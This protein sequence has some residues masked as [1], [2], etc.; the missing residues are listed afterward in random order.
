MAEIRVLS[1]DGGGIRGIIPATVLRYIE[2]QTGRPICDHFHL[3][4]GTSTGGILA[5]GLSQLADGKP[6]ASAGDLL[7]L[8]VD[9]GG[10]IF[11]RSALKKIR[12]VGGLTD[13]KYSARSLTRAL[14]GVLRDRWLGDVV[15]DLL[16][17]AYDI[18]NRRPHFFKSWRARGE[19]WD[20]DTKDED[21]GSRDFSLV[22]VVRSTSAAP[23]YFEPALVENRTRADEYALVDGGVFANNPSVCALASARRIYK[24]DGNDIFV[25]SLGT[26]LAQEAIEY[27]D[28]KDWGLV[29]WARK[30][31][32]IVFDGVSDAADYQLQQ[33][34]GPQQAVRLDIDLGDPEND[35]KAP[36]AA[37]DDA[38]DENIALLVGRGEQLLQEQAKRLGEV[39]EKLKTPKADIGSLRP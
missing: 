28:A 26:G 5:T 14:R 35:K 1:I 25:L 10:E 37:F 11:S 32:D 15:S 23:T 39:V 3:I 20:S 22:D 19:R 17:T 9:R 18:E 16:V 12:S 2:E 31:I 24:Q 21:A 29:G 4:A 8:Y 13:E 30:V 34:L 36:R 33:I 7:G 27:D 38:S 6:V